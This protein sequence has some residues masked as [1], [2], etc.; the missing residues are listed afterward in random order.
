MVEVFIFFVGLA[1]AQRNEVELYSQHQTAFCELWKTTHI[2][3]IHSLETLCHR[4]V[5]RYGDQVRDFFQLG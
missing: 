4:R 5:R 1:F 3:Q 2:Y